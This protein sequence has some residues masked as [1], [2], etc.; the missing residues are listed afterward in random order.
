MEGLERSVI[1]K[2]SGANKWALIWVES[3]AVISI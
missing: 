3:T 2:V 1:F